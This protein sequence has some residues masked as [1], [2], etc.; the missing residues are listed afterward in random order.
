M[1]PELDNV[2]QCLSLN[3]YSVLSLISDILAHGSNRE[4]RTIK[5][6]LEGVERDAVDICARLLNHNTT[7]TS[8]FT[9]ALGV[10]LQS[11]TRKEHSPN[12]MA[13]HPLSLSS[14]SPGLSFG[15]AS[16]PTHSLEDSLNI[17][18]ARCT[19]TTSSIVFSTNS[20]SVACTVVKYERVIIIDPLPDDIFLEIF[21]LCLRDLTEYSV[22]SMRKWVTLVHV[23]KRWRRIIFAS[24]RRLDLYITCIYRSPAKRNLVYWPLSFPL[25]IDYRRRATSHGP[26]S[27]DDDNIVATLTYADRI[28]R[29]NI[30][31]G[32]SLVR[33]V[34][35]VMQKSFPMLTRLELTWVREDWAGP[36]PDLPPGFLG[37]SAPRLEF[38]S[39]SGVSFPSYPTFL[40][41]A[42]NL[43]D[44]QLSEILQTIPPETMVAGLAVLTRLSTL[45][46]EF[47]RLTPQ[48]DQWETRSN[49]PMPTILPALTDFRYEG[50]S[51]YLE[52]LLALISTPLIDNIRIKY[53]MED[54]QVLQLSQFIGRTKNLK[55]VQFRRAHAIFH[56]FVFDIELEPELQEESQAYI[57]L[58]LLGEDIQVPDVVDVLGQLDTMF[59]DVDHLSAYGDWQEWI[60]MD[61]L[62]STAWLPFLRLFPAMEELTLCGK[63]LPCIASALEDIT[64]EMLTEVM[65][66][67]H[68][69]WLDDG[70]RAEDSDIDGPIR[71]IEQ[72]LSFRQ[73]S[74]RPVTVVNVRDEF[75]ET[76]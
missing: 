12:F 74:G 44:L 14:V 21:D 75:N 11:Q 29:I 52:N 1:R 31:A 73:L 32:S 24:P 58:T 45:S 35:T 66:E 69:L 20:D 50:H 17:G 28:H 57:I 65:P 60:G 36:L 70:D 54:I 48:P 19:C 26:S 63:V 42:S 34:V 7:S 71:S 68:L 40:L 16:R 4:D 23:C 30:Y 10:A 76:L 3:G 61:D 9:W 2:L 64:E 46:I 13:G 18:K 55:D 47:D 39:L 41:S 33:K 22:L 49:P 38:L 59:S 6:L 8:V 25:V 53:F 67:L 27:G 72:F 15:T 51:A 5:G 62:D 43:L 37:G 56:Y